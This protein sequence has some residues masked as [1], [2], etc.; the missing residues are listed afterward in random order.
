[1]PLQR[2][3]RLLREDDPL[4]RPTNRVALFVD[5]ENIRHSLEHHFDPPPSAQVL[6]EK[7]FEVS[8]RYGPRSV[9]PGFV[10]TL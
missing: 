10:T 7:L 3:E 1:M 2:A 4:C 6:C 8:S 9:V 5:Y